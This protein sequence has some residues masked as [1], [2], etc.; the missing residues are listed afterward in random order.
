MQSI[1]D[2]LKSINQ[3]SDFKSRQKM[4]ESQY[5]K[6]YAGTSEQN[7]MML[8]HILKSATQSPMAPYLPFTYMPATRAMGAA[9]DA[10]GIR[11]QGSGAPAPYRM[12]GH[13]MQQMAGPNNPYLPPQQAPQQ[14]AIEPAMLFENLLG[15][16]PFM[17]FANA[18]RGASEAS[19]IM[20]NPARSFYNSVNN[21]RNPY[22]P[23]AS[24]TMQLSTNRAMGQQADD[25][26]SI[27]DRIRQ[28]ARD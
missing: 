5:G 21:V 28:M 4:Y 27:I 2:Y 18:A 6:P 12:F 11:G 3:P 8:K 24:P 14:D 19:T 1:V 25:A 23:P 7:M 9:A 17:K 22:L 16:L 26:L 20:P 13:M 15:A 10:L